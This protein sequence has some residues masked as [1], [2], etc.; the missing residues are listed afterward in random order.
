M[1]DVETFLDDT[2][3]E[4][5]GM[6]A[7]D[8]RFEH[9]IIQRDN[10]SPQH[11]LGARS[12][13]RVIEVEAGFNAAFVDLGAP[14]PAAFLP[15]GQGPRPR[16]GD[17]IEV[18]TSAEPRERKGP[19][20]RL[21]GPAEGSPRLLAPGPDVRAELAR[22]APRVSI[23]T[24]PAAIQA[25][26]D[27]EEEALADGD[28][29]ADLAL[30]LAVQRTR[31][32]IAVDIDYAHLPGRDA[33]AGRHR[34]NLE[35]LRQAARLIRLKNWGG[36]VAIDLVGARL[37]ADTIGRAARAAFADEPEVVFGPLNRFG[38]LQLSLPWRRTP[39]EDRLR[40]WDGGRLPM[41]TALATVRR[42]RMRLLQDTATPRF[43]ARC[44]PGEAALA[45][46]LVARLGPRAAVVADPAVRPGHADIEEG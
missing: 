4:T 12:V 13:G 36:L 23:Q 33:K 24:G 9:L 2:P 5:R 42:L 7:R 44:A 15:M 35:G 25:S 38:V 1:S 30:D 46:P 28:F 40:G 37:D 3:G 43:T 14:G 22:L 17:R 6:V 20:V 18:Q 21:I 16:E 45:A 31:A 19:T 39:I 8:G 11:R 32:L 34:A 29:F 27:A 10:D 41:T 26:W